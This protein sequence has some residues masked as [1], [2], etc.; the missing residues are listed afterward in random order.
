MNRWPSVLILGLWA[1][2]AGAVDITFPS[3]SR[4]ISDRASTFDSYQVPVAPWSD[5]AVETLRFEGRVDR[6]SWRLES[7]AITTLQLLDPLRQ[8]LD[9]AGYETLLDCEAKT[10]GGFDFRFAIEVIPTPDMYVDIRDYRF[11]S[12]RKDENAITL[13]VSRS[14]TAGY[15]QIIQVGP[16]ENGSLYIKPDGE[17]PISASA[18]AQDISAKLIEFGHVAL[19]DL[20][21]EVGTAEL[22]QTAYT[23]LQELAEFMRANPQALIALVGHTDTTGALDVNIALSQRRAAAVRDRMITAH[24]IA[25]GRIQAEGMGY[26][27]P[28]A[29]NLTQIGRERNRR[30]EA[31][32]LSLE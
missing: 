21:F 27:S 3:G 20:E 13:M 14:R 9:A 25:A 28:R 4:L 30:V 10:C 19:S 11:V 5:G 31:I 17:A 8:Q 1:S 7:S 16:P 24:S 15:F 23:S 12:A 2:T 32:L 26:L 29:S 22:S 6:Q 18:D